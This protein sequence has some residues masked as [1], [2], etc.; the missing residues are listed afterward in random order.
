[1]QT[2]V[3]RPA[4]LVVVTKGG[5]SESQILLK[6]LIRRSVIYKP[7]GG[8]ALCANTSVARVIGQSVWNSGW[9]NISV[10]SHTTLFGL[11]DILNLVAEFDIVL[12]I[13][14]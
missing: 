12:Q 3:L 10:I 5:G 13:F 9:P 2:E 4:A 11:S 7:A 1:M 14:A 8:K 6:L